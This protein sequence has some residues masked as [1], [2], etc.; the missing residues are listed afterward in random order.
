VMGE[1]QIRL[2]N[3]F[4]ELRDRDKRILERMEAGSFVTREV[5]DGKRIDTTAKDIG[6]LRRAVAA[7]DRLIEEI[8]G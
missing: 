3:A 4:C 1:D 6:T 5:I 8:I 7:M 2:L